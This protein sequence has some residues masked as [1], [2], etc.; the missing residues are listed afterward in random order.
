MAATFTQ[1]KYSSNTQILQFDNTQSCFPIHRGWM[2]LLAIVHPYAIRGDLG[3]PVGS[4]LDA[5]LEALILAYTLSG[6]SGV[7]TKEDCRRYFDMPENKAWFRMHGI[8]DLCQNLVGE[9]M[10]LSTLCFL[11]ACLLSSSKGV[12]LSN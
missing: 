8:T 11:F 5:E 10:P 12:L 3:L 4:S 1:L 9:Y 7:L 6:L 2:F